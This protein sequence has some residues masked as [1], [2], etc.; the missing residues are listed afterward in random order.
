MEVI[1]CGALT[2]PSASLR[3]KAALEEITRRTRVG[4]G[5]HHR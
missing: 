1:A 4:T 5:H 3:A 2:R